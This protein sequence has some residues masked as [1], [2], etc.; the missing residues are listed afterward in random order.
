MNIIEDIK[1]HIREQLEM[2]RDNNLKLIKKE[3]EG[4]K[5]V[6]TIVKV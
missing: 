2:E 5:S 6:G 4:E 3:I 1:K